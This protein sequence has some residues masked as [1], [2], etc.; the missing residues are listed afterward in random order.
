MESRLG[1]SD[2][3][4]APWASDAERDSRL[5]RKANDEVRRQS[6]TLT[7]SEPAAFFCECDTNGCYAPVFL[8]LADFDAMVAAEQRVWVLSEGHKPSSGI[9]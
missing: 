4:E 1:D 5:M 8:S 7:S 6:D 2:P 9:A 3:S